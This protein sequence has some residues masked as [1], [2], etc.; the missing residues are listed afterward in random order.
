EKAFTA[1]IAENA[2]NAEKEIGLKRLECSASSAYSAPSAVKL[3]IYGLRPTQYFF[4]SSQAGKLFPGRGESS[5]LA[6]CGERGNTAAGAGVRAKALRS[7]RQ[8][9]AA[10]ARW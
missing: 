4:R 10:Y 3:L 6:A 2:E 5:A 1:E 9:R 7:Q 8:A